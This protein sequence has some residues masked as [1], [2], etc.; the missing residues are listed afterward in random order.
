MEV[1]MPVLPLYRYC[2]DAESRLRVCLARLQL[3]WWSGFSGGVGA[4]LKN[5]W[6]N[7]FICWFTIV[8]CLSYHSLFFFILFLNF[9]FSF[10]ATLL[11]PYPFVVVLLV[12]LRRAPLFSPARPSPAHGGGGEEEASPARST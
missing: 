12:S 6:Q 2:N 7:G 3:L 11:S 5:V 1:Y 9:F 8:K 4:V 10:F